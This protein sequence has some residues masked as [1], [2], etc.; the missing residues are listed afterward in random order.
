M[1]LLF[2]NYS[3][4]EVIHLDYFEKDEGLP[5]KHK[6]CWWKWFKQTKLTRAHQTLRER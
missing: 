2:K 1:P 4:L 6:E 3:F 5:M